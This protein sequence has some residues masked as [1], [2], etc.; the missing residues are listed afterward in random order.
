LHFGKLFE[1]WIR[2]SGGGVRNTTSTSCFSRFDG[3]LKVFVGA[4]NEGERGWRWGGGGETERQKDREKTEREERGQENCE[5]VVS[6]VIIVVN[7]CQGYSGTKYSV[8]RNY[9]GTIYSVS[10]D[11]QSNIQSAGIFRYNILSQ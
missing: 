3:L 5:R 2:P 6:R 9:S 8:S 1:H 10:R 7:K 11:L 4:Y